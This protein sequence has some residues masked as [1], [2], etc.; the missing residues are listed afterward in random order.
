MLFCLSDFFQYYRRLGKYSRARLDS[1]GHRLATLENLERYRNSEGISLV[2][3]HRYPSFVS[4][5]I[6]WSTSSIYSH[7][8]ILL[9]GGMASHMTTSGH[10]LQ[11]VSDFADNCSY[12]LVQEITRD[13]IKIAA[14][15]GRMNLIDVKNLK[16]NWVGAISLGLTDLLSMNGKFRPKHLCDI[17]VLA[18]LIYYSSK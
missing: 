2:M 9:P 8:A 15:M 13:P 18:L 4:W 1:T 16:Y 12:L 6:M 10:L 7:S 3:V 14:M 17:A 5:I 11:S